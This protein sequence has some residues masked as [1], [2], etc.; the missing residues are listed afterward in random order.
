MSSAVVIGIGGVGKEILMRIRR[1]IVEKYGSLDS[2]PYVQFLHIDTEVDVK[3]TY[4]EQFVMGES[5]RFSTEERIELSES[6]DMELLHDRNVQDWF[7][8]RLAENLGKVNFRDGAGGIRSYGRF[9]F[10]CAIERFNAELQAKA[11]K[12]VQAGEGGNVKVYIVSSLFG[13]TGG[14]GFLDLCYNV[15]KPGVVAG[16][17][18]VL[19]FFVVGGDGIKDPQKANCY[20]ALKELEYFSTCGKVDEPGFRVDYPGKPPGSGVNDRGAPVDTCYHN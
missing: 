19:G 15:K 18:E 3:S 12:A 20:S 13:G 4:T 1:M 14:G 9:A 8:D 5:I 2:L 10:H 6:I 7:P 16:L 11:R 17:D